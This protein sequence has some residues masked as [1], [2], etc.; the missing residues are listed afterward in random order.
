MWIDITIPLVAGLGTWPGDP[1]LRLRRLADLGRG[2]SCNLSAVSLC[3]HAGTHL[4][5]PLHYLAGGAAVDQAPPELLMGAA[6]VVEA[7]A[8]GSIGSDAIPA[9]PAPRLLF[10]TRNSHRRWWTEPF[11]ED[12]A[13]LS[14]DAAR[15]L[16][17]LG[18][19]LVGID[20]PS[21]GPWGQEGDEVH[22]LLLGA[23]IWIL[24]GLDL[25]AA[26]PGACQ[27]ICLP[28]R[29]AGAEA[30]PARAFLLV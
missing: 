29:L 9:E 27:L 10:K 15:A 26:A 24:E 4:D 19:R 2:D 14:L 6:Q 3:A 25:S 1:R 22:R 30:A 23:G 8:A 5:A 18:A 12:F 7:A 13:A 16:A 17:G 11:R 20:G 28:L 21:I